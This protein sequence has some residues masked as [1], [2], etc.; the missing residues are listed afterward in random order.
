MRTVSVDTKAL[1][2]AHFSGGGGGV[3][4]HHLAREFSLCKKQSVGSPVVASTAGSRGTAEGNVHG[5]G[6]RSP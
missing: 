1:G 5:G 4:Y 3:G 2:L 6:Q